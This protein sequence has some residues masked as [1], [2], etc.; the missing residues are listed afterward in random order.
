MYSSLTHFYSTV[1]KIGESSAQP[2]PKHIVNYPML[3]HRYP[4]PV[5]TFHNSDVNVP[6]ELSQGEC[7]KVLIAKHDLFPQHLCVLVDL[8]FVSGEFFDISHNKKVRSMTIG[9]KKMSGEMN[10]GAMM[11]YN[12][13]NEFHF[14]PI[15]HEKL[16]LRV[17]DEILQEVGF[18]LPKCETDRRTIS[19]VEEILQLAFLGTIYLKPQRPHGDYTHIQLENFRKRAT[20]RF[21][22]CP[23]PWSLDM[24]LTEG[25]MSLLMYGQDLCNGNNSIQSSL[26][27]GVLHKTP[28]RLN[29]PF[30][31]ALLWR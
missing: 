9:R 28:V 14:Q 8:S 25:G 13:D 22:H 6:P 21:Q 30:K 27:Q 16:L 17:F 7:S 23:Y 12:P 11:Y 26:K 2:Q 20:Q 24:P 1:F 5:W 29:V 10:G 4:D 18:K 3:P 15:G 31:H 19:L